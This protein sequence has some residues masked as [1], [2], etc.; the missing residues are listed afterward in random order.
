[1]TSDHSWP[2]EHSSW[3]RGTMDGFVSTHTSSTYEGALGIMTMGYYKR[4]DMPFY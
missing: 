3:H 4:A 1:M 2:A